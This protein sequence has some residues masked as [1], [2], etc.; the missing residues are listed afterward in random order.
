[1]SQKEVYDIIKE[2][3]GEATYREIKR[4]AK[5]KFPNLTLFP[6]D[7]LWRDVK[8]YAAKKGLKLTQVVEV[9]LREYIKKE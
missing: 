9:A 2:L 3:G 7:S 4:R 8:V 1:M 5:E 6:L